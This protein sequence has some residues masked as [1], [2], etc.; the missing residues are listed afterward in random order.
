MTW[1][2]RLLPQSPRLPRLAEQNHR[3]RQAQRRRRMATLEAL[4]G[5]TLLSNVVLSYATAANGQNT[6]IITGDTFN[7]TF[8]V[9]DNNATG[10]VTVTGSPRTLINNSSIP[11]KTTEQVSEIA[12]IL[13]GNHNSTDNVTITSTGSGQG[14]IANISIVAPGVVASP[15]VAGLDLTLNVTGLTLTGELSVWDAP[16][17]AATTAVPLLPIVA[18]A[19]GQSTTANAPTTTQIP[20]YV[21]PTTGSPA[22]P[23]NNL[24]GLLTASVTGSHLGSLYI[25]QDGCCVANVTLNND[26]V[27]GSLTVEEGVANGDTITLTNSTAGTTTL[28]QG[29]GPT[30]AGC[31]GSGD[32]VTVQD[33]PIPSTVVPAP[34]STSGIL[35]LLIAQLGAG[36]GEKIL[37]GNVSPVEVGLVGFGIEATQHDTGTAPGNLIDIESIT[38]YASTQKSSSPFGSLGPPSIV[39]VQGADG[40]DQT[41]IDSSVIPGNISVTQGNGV[42]DN[43]TLNADT[44]GYTTPLAGGLQNA[45]YGYVTLTQG[46]GT[47]DHIFLSSASSEAPLPVPNGPNVFANGLLIIQGYGGGDI[48][49]VDSTIVLG[50]NSRFTGYIIVVQGNGAGDEVFITASTAGYTTPA[51]PYGGVIDHGGLLIVVQGNGY[52][53]SI[54]I[55]S[56]GLESPPD[57]GSVFNDVLLI[58]GASTNGDN[59]VCTQATGDVISIDETTIYDNL[60]ILQNAKFALTP[61]ASLAATLGPVATD[62]AGTLITDGPGLGDNIVNIGTGVAT[63]YANFV[64]PPGVPTITTGPSQTYVGEETFIYQGGADNTVNLGGA[65]YYLSTTPVGDPYTDPDFQTAFLDIW[66]GAGGGGFVSADNTTVVYGSFFGLDYVIDGGGGGNT[67]YDTLGNQINGVP[68][69][70][71]YNTTDYSS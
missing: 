22:V 65:N 53:D 39:T 69:T 48:V 20:G 6:L 51:G 15:Q 12:I 4:E 66:T 2:S 63:N 13:P 18:T 16:T 67:Y 37:V 3:T 9:S 10:Y 41:I 59:V 56:F 54:N 36:G 57:S 50:G 28:L 8:T 52:E 25:E 62:P 27:S 35:D 17:S 43:I 49:S 5:R 14:T 11:Q 47:G 7:D 33:D 26:T 30:M 44:A 24:G 55:T 58:Q 42:S 1:L 68:G 31:N 34:P 38:T 19:S 61:G 21:F 64:A 71:P 23:S 29:Y 46:Y 60:V 45:Y 70:L 32:L 40:N